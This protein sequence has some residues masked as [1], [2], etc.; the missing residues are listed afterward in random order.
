[1]VIIDTSDSLTGRPII[2]EV[3]VSNESGL[4]VWRSTGF[5]D[6]CLALE[7]QSTDESARR[8]VLRTSRA[9]GLAD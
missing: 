2:V 4:Q 1:M 9:S 6:D 3:L 8:W 5:E 7:L